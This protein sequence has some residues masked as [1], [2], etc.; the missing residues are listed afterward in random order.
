MKERETPLVVI[1]LVGE[2]AVVEQL[3]DRLQHNFN[4]PTMELSENARE[5]ADL[6]QQPDPPFRLDA[7][8]GHLAEEKRLAQH[9]SDHFMRQVLASIAHEDIPGPVIVLRGTLRADEVTTLREQL[10]DELIV[11]RAV[12]AEGRAADTPVAHL[13]D[14]TFAVAS[15]ARLDEQIRRE[16][17]PI[18]PPSASATV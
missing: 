3:S 16:L 8:T 12:E 9:G 4:L 15:G 10:G 18:L 13:A 1:G 6:E 17:L 14:L 11:V 2:T 7:P 5:F